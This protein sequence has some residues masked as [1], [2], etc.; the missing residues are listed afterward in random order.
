MIIN[1]YIYKIIRYFIKNENLLDN[2][3]TY[4]INIIKKMKST[5]SFSNFKTSSKNE[6]VIEYK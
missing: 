3:K 6:F 4:E 1:T 2:Y 5:I